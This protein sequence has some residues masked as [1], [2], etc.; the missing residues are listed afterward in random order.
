MGMFEISASVLFAL[1]RETTLRKGHYLC[2]SFDLTS[3]IIN[4]F[5][6]LSKSKDRFTVSSEKPVAL[7]DQLLPR[8]FGCMTDVCHLDIH[9]ASGNCRYILWNRPAAKKDS[10]QADEIETFGV[11]KTFSCENGLLSRWN[12]QNI[13]Y[14]IFLSRFY[15]DLS[16]YYVVLVNIG[17]L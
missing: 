12:N 3:R 15:T 10:S 13:Y 9:L 4:T 16:T 8:H 6:R 11:P 7:Y 2:R 1:A 14:G 17:P 5:E